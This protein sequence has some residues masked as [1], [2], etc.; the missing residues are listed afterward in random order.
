MPAAM[1]SSPV[2]SFFYLLLLG[3]MLLT[4]ALVV[5]SH[6]LARK[7]P[8]APMSAAMRETIQP[9]VRRL[10]PAEE[11]TIR[12]KFPGALATA[13]GLRTIVRTPG[14]GPA[15][16]PGQTVTVHYEGRL[17]DGT[18]FDSSR[19]RGEPLVF[20]V[21]AGRVIPGWDEA[22]MMMQP[23]EKRTLI[24]PFWLAYGED[25][26]PPTIPPRATLV[27]DVELLDVH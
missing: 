23:G 11:Q 16:R 18:L 5:D 1:A 8:G 3:A 10:T 14:R 6:L 19:T 15:P 27:F 26:H 20:P 13:S 2:R 4:L 21:G 17:L 7:D 25:G 24:I 22:L 12:E 9:E